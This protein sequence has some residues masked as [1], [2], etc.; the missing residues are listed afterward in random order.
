MKADCC[1]V[2]QNERVDVLDISFQDN[3]DRM[4]KQ[5]FN[6]LLRCVLAMWIIQGHYKAYNQA[7][8]IF[9]FSF[10]GES[11]Y[12]SKLRW[13][14]HSF[15]KNF[16]FSAKSQGNWICLCPHLLVSKSRREHSFQTNYTYYVLK[17]SWRIPRNINFCTTCWLDI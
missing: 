13:G 15:C 11:L 9:K 16:P 2:E 10:K 6:F 4:L 12:I 3:S 17:I 14:N 1:A 5:F 8:W 7:R